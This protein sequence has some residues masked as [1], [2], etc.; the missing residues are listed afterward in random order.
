MRLGGLCAGILFAL[1]FAG[2]ADSS[3]TATGDD[4]LPAEVDAEAGVFT[5]TLG[6]VREGVGLAQIKEGHG[7]IAFMLILKNNLP[8]TELALN[9]SSPDGQSTEV[10]TGPILYVLPGNRPTV[11]F[12]EPVAGMWKA[13]V[14]LES[15]ATAD[16]EV[17]WCADDAH[18]PGPQDNL[19]CHRDYD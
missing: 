17:H 16:Y 5:G 3:P 8:E 4:A 19:A 10:D 15:G 18:A 11:A 14:T 7:R 6:T 12:D 9:V 13:V 1:L 2:C